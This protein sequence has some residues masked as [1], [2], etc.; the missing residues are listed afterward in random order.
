MSKKSGK[1]KSLAEVVKFLYEKRKVDVN[2][3]KED[4]EVSRNDL[5]SKM[6]TLKRNFED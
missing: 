1:F 2:D 4:M 6:A 5:K 3:L